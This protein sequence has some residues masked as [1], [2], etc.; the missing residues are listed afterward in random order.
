MKARTIDIKR[1]AV[2]D[3]D[4]IRTTLFL[5]GCSL[6]C[7]WCHNPEGISFEPQLAYYENK[8]VGCGECVSV[9]PSGAHGIS[10]NGH[11][12]DRDKCMGC[13][14]CEEV[15][16][17]DALKLYGKEVTVDEILPKPSRTFLI[18]KLLRLK[19]PIHCKN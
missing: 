16:L 13:G 15:C 19:M 4:G 6:K 10:E 18:S 3:G 12:F 1:F 11:T 7:L 5:K 2:H 8:C 17:G 14:K 9:C